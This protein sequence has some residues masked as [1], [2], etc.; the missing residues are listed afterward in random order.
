[1]LENLKLNHTKRK[2]TKDSNKECDKNN[3]AIW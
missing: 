1:V 2:E 3:Q